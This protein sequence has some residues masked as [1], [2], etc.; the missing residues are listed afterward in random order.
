MQRYPGDPLLR[1]LI[2]EGFVHGIDLCGLCIMDT[3]VDNQVSSHPY[4]KF[5]L[6]NIH[7]RKAM[8]TQ[9]IA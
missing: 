6:L 4:Q 5:F 1:S 2:S 8:K 7:I 9:V 3:F